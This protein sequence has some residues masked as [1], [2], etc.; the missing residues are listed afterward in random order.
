MCSRVLTAEVSNTQKI[1]LNRSISV[2]YMVGHFTTSGHV[3]TA[4][5]LDCSLMKSRYFITATLVDRLAAGDVAA[6][7]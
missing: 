5:G 1:F 3:F 2:T 6:L 4:A 7:V